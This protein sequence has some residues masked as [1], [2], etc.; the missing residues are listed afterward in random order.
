MGVG[1]KVGQCQWTR[2]GFALGADREMPDF[3]RY[4]MSGDSENVCDLTIYPVLPID[5]GVYQC[6]VG[7][8]EGSGPIAA[9]PVS[10]RVNS[11]PGQPHIVQGQKTDQME[12]EKGKV[13]ELECESNGGRPAP[14]IDW[15]DGTG[16]KIVSDVTHHVSKIYETGLFR[17]S[18]VLRLKLEMPK[19][20]S[21]I[22]HS[23]AYP[24][25]KVSRNL[26]VTFRRVLNE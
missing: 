20:I 11:P 8:G 12:V 5:E 26:E 6:Q 13:I 22:A 19:V 24:T 7:G 1:N 17:T 23:D 3:P 25:S 10:L 21:C 9:N 14:E 2:D 15:V 16:N 4:T 18:S